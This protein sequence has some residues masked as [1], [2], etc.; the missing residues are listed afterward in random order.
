MG[1]LLLRVEWRSRDRRMLDELLDFS[2]FWG[3]RCRRS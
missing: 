3:M 2:T 1:R